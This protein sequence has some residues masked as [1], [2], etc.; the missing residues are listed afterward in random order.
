VAAD[1]L[2]A[3]DW[4][5][6][7]P[8]LSLLHETFA[9]AGATLLPVGPEDLKGAFDRLRAG[10]SPPRAYLDRATDTSPE[11]GPL[12]DWAERNI[13]LHLNRRTPPAGVV[14]NQSSLGVHPGWD[15]HA[16]HDRHPLDAPTGGP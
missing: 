3:Y 9:A 16:V 7:R 8:F 6:D 12:D 11:F 1:L 5:Y 4:P 2:L 10:A 13:S 14:Q 15:S